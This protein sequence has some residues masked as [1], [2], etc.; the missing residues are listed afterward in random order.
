MGVGGAQ[1]GPAEEG[2]RGGGGV[3]PVVLEGV[4]GLV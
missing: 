1:E 3:E 4:Q 2:G